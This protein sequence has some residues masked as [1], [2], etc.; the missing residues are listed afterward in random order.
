MDNMN[1]NDMNMNDNGFNAQEAEKNGE[2]ELYAFVA[3][4]GRLK[5]SS[6]N[7]SFLC[8]MKLLQMLEDSDWLQM[9]HESRFGRFYIL[10]DENSEKLLSLWLEAFKLV[11]LEKM[12]RFMSELAWFSR[13][14]S[15]DIAFAVCLQ[16]FGGLR[17]GEVL[18]VRQ[19]GSCLG[20][21]INVTM[22][23]SHAERIEIDLRKNYCL[24]ED[25][26]MTGSIKRNRIATILPSF[27]PAVHAAYRFHLQ[28]LEGRSYDR[29]LAPMFIDPAGNAMDLQTYRSKMK[30]LMDSFC[31]EAPFCSQDEDYRAL[32]RLISPHPSA[33]FRLPNVLL[34]VLLAAG[35]DLQ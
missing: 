20:P 5:A 4:L 26:M 12:V 10:P 34:E 24:R 9:P 11:P 2:V 23:G 33:S 3:E 14:A 27:L 21:G 6:Y 13:K 31:R 1:M 17:N 30:D 16:L 7:D 8:R 32:V 35:A 22:Q 25:G 18:C 28:Y 15:P 19:A 29:T